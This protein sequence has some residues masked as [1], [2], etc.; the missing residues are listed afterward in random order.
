MT[1]TFLKTFPRHTAVPRRRVMRKY[2][3]Q[4]QVTQS[5]LPLP[6]RQKIAGRDGDQAKC[7]VTESLTDSFP[8]FRLKMNLERRASHQSDFPVVKL[9][10]DFHIP[11]S[12]D[13]DAVRFENFVKNDHLVF[14]AVFFQGD[15]DSA[16]Q[17]RLG[18]LRGQDPFNNQTADIFLFLVFSALIDLSDDKDRLVRHKLFLGDLIGFW[19]DDRMDRVAG[20]F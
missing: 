5:R 7:V 15:A 6:P 20:I 1:Y 13:R 9:E 18:L 16:D 2:G 10:K 4:G 14:F 19:I 12:S 11:P 3:R 17:I 8:D